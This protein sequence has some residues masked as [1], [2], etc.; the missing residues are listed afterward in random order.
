MPLRWISVE[1][2]PSRV[3]TIP[4]LIH[5]TAPKVGPASDGE[6]YFFKRGSV[7]TVVAEALAYSLAE[8]VGLSVPLWALCR[9]PPDNEIYFASQAVSIN[10]GVDSLIEA[11]ETVNPEL[12]EECIAFDIWTANTDRNAGNIVASPAI[13]R[14]GVVELFAIDF[15]QAKVLNG[16]DF[17]TVGSL[18]SRECWPKGALARSCEHLDFPTSMCRSIEGMTRAALDSALADIG[19]DIEFPQVPW[20]DSAKRQATSRATRIEALVAEAWNA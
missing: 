20:L 13:D 9:M 8:A 16:T 4:G 7:E 6:R 18:H 19:S 5:R 3:V 12:L 10:S 1:V 14:Q 11:G 17:L 2:E 15:E